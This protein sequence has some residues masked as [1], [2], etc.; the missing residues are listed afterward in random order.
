L[1]EID[2]DAVWPVGAGRA[3]VQLLDVR[4]NG[5]AA[6][7]RLPG[8]IV[9]PI[10]DDNERHEVGKSYHHEGHDAATRLGHELTA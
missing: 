10:L 3:A 7:A 4:S 1:H 2:A 9:S 8:A 5:E 6:R